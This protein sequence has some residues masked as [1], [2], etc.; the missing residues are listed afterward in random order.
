MKTTLTVT[1]LL[2]LFC[3]F[4]AFA[5]TPVRPNGWYYVL[6]AEKDSLS[7]EPIVTVADFSELELDSMQ[8]SGK[9]SVIYHIVGKIKEAKWAAWEEATRKSI[10][11]QIGFLFNGNLLT[12]PHVNAEIKTGAFFIA[13]DKVQ[14][15]REL[16]Q[17][18]RQ[19]AGC[20]EVYKSTEV[21]KP[22]LSPAFWAIKGGLVVVFLIIFYLGF[23]ALRRIK[24]GTASK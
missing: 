9:D 14:N 12:T 16:Y 22:P 7:A 3:C 4:S 15:M 10:G 21:P 24:R 18:I 13:T 19:E 8:A 11:K 2:I 23:W 6:D 1:L 5:D 20:E 17:Q